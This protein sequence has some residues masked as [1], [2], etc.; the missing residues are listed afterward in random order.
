M[1]QLPNG[2]QRPLC[3]QPITHSLEEL[4]R[5]RVR[6]LY[7][8][9]EP[10][11]FI[12]HLDEFRLW[13]RALRRADLPLL[14][15]R[16]FNPQPHMQFAS[17]LGV[18]FTGAREPL[19]ITFAPPLPLVELRARIQAKLPPGVQIHAIDEVPLK[20]T[21]L[22]S[23]LI[24]A[25]YSIIIYAEPGELDPQQIGVAIADFLTKSELWSERERKGAK[26]RYNLRPL[27][28]ELRYQGYDAAS[29]EHRIFLRVQQREG[30]TGR[31]D[32]VVSALGLHNFARTLRRE[33][34]Y[35]S[36][37]EADAALF[38]TYP[39]VEKADINVELAGRR[40][41]GRRGSKSNNAPKEG[42]YAREARSINERAAD[43][44]V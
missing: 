37:N 1:N 10:I 24:G 18:G 17:P 12:S 43:E 9:G 35:T 29:E 11:K 30:A 32:E 36:D 2:A 33:R 23:V 5:Q 26:Y 8:K 19:D 4:P 28:Y 41:K 21:S 15:K 42:K 14:Y 25:D 13:E 3:E 38:A 16:G 40:L 20:T 7:E 31:P 6:I 39:V 27:V 44:F 22:Q 34:L